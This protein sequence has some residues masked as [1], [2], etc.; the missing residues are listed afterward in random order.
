MVRYGFLNTASCHHRFQL[1]AH[2]PVVHLAKHQFVFLQVFVA[3]DNLQGYVHQLHL[4][5]NVGLVALADNSLVTIDVYD[6]VR[7]QVLHVDE[8]EGGEAHEYKNVTHEGEIVILELMGY[9]SLQFLLGQELP[10][11]AV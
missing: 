7:G 1:L 9:D 11:L 3:V 5:G 10:F 8:R 4:K 2:G 6:V